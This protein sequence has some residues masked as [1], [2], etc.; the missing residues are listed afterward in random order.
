MG[1]DEGYSSVSFLSGLLL[2]VAVGAGVALLLA[3]QSGRR[4]RRAL[5]RSVEDVT[6]TAVDRWDDMTEEVRSA[7]RSSRKKLD[8]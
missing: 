2:G 7:V 1:Y 5:L 3:P 8:L 6:D 4:T